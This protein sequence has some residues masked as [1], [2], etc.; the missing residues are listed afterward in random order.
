[1]IPVETLRRSVDEYSF[2]KFLSILGIGRN[3]QVQSLGNGPVMIRHARE[4]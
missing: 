4:Y 3:E 2:H 1:M